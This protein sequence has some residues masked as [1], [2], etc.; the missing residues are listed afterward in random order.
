[1]LQPDFFADD[2]TLFTLRADLRSTLPDQPPSAPQQIPQADL[3]AALAPV[4]RRLKIGEH[5]LDYTLLRSKRRSIGFVISDD[6]LR[7]TAPKWVTLGDIKLA[8]LEKKRWIL[9]KLS[10]YRDR[11]T[12]RMQ[13]Q[14]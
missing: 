14:M 11:S 2:S 13:P 3:P 4:K 7:V 12:R 6:D 9:T 5:V 10:E 8:I 1:M